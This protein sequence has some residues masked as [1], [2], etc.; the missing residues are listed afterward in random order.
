MKHLALKFALTLIFALSFSIMYSQIFVDSINVVRKVTVKMNNGEEF[1]GDVIKQDDDILILNS[2]NGELKIKVIQIKKIE[3]YTYEGDFLF[4]SS[5]ATRYFFGPSAIPLKKGKGYY[6]NVYLVGNFVNVGIT[7]NFS[8]G[9]GLEFFSTVYG[10]PIYFLTP[11]VGFEV[12]ENVHVGGGFLTAGMVGEGNVTMGYGVSTLGSS[13][14]N[15][16]FGMGFGVAD[17][18]LGV[19]FVFSG[20][21]RVSNSIALLT[22]NYV[23]KNSQ[24]TNNSYI[25]IHGIRILGRKHSFDFGL[26]VLA[27]VVPLP[28]VAYSKSF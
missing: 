4:P 2:K 6:H 12:K 21:T 27:G 8:F 14:K 13:D 15:A 28:Y 25:G 9:G 20:T 19:T 1:V 5:H 22:E 10:R 3:E 16:S 18:D 23:F 11:K 7:D 24:N 26:L 17:D